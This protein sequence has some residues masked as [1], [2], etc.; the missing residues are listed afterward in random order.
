ME[1]E[2]EVAEELV[3]EAHEIDLEYE[4]DAVRFFDFTR[5]ETPAE[6]RDAEIWFE[7]AKSYPPSRESLYF[8]IQK[9]EGKKKKSKIHAC[10]HGVD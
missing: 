8:L 4:F 10:F 6:A 3:F 5:E 1:V 2:G 9:K 7:S